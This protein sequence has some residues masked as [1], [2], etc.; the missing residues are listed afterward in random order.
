MSHPIKAVFY[1]GVALGIVL[2]LAISCAPPS[3][4]KNPDAEK[5]PSTQPPPHKPSIITF[6]KF[7]PIEGGDKTKFNRLTHCLT[8]GY[9]KNDLPEEKQK[10]LRKEFQI[11]FENGEYDLFPIL[12]NGLHG[13]D[14]L[15][16]HGVNNAHKIT[17]KWNV[18]TGKDFLNCPFREEDTEQAM[19]K[20]LKWNTKAVH[21]IINIW[22]KKVGDRKNQEKFF[23]HILY[24]KTKGGVKRR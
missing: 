3:N 9:L 19:E 2:F 22:K 13:L 23:N 4:D 21:S 16:K 24:A 15:T 6:E 8:Q 20:N 1:P 10:E 11:A 18:L 12:L 7:P 14:L 17:M 5:Q